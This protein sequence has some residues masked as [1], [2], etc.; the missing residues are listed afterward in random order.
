[1]PGFTMKGWLNEKPGLCLVVRDEKHVQGSSTYVE[2]YS[3]RVRRLYRRLLYI[4]FVF[5]LRVSD[6]VASGTVCTCHTCLLV[7]CP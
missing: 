1:M 6:V 7:V 5:E 3:A 4:W 2:E